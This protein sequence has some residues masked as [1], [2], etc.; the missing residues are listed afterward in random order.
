V[1]PRLDRDSRFVVAIRVEAREIADL[2]RFLDS[3]EKTGAFHNV[4]TKDEQATDD[5]LLEAVIEGL[6]VQRDATGEKPAA[7]AQGGAAGD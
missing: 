7:T 2:E 6:Y 5:G 1:Q 4:L 3:L